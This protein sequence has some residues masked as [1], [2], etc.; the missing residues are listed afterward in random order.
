MRHRSAVAALFALVVVTAGCVGT[1]PGTQTG[2][3]DPTE[4]ST[5]ASDPAA[6]STTP[7][8]PSGGVDFPEGPTEPPDRPAAFNAPSVREYVESYE[9]RI[10]Y[11]SLWVNENTSVTLDCRVDDVTERTWGYE[12]VVTCTGSSETNGLNADWFTQ[13]YRYRVSESTLDRTG[14][15]PREPVS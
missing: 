6:T 13:T 2:G 3:P 7:P 4:T 1:D 12:A 10:A 8:P 9:Y 15:E 11:N 5:T 14:I